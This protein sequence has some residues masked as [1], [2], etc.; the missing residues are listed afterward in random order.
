VQLDQ[1]KKN[2]ARQR[3]LWGQHL[4]TRGRWKRRRNDVKGA[5]S[6]LQEREKQVGSQAARIA[7]ERAG[8]EAPLRSSK[9]RIESPI[10]GIVNAPAI[11]RKVKPRVTA[12]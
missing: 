4:T 8:L 11:F 5:E 3:E 2:L 6:S 9:V 10:D 1:I 12:R 7:Q